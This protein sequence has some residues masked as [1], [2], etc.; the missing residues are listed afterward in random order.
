MKF[1]NLLVF[2]TLAGIFTSL[3]SKE[4]NSNDFR[5]FSTN[6]AEVSMKVMAEQLAEFDVVFFFE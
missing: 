4:F 3:S 5:I 6:G 1:S 2:V